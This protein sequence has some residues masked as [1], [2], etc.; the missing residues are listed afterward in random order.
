MEFICVS[1]LP[2]QTSR[3]VAETH[4]NILNMLRFIFLVLLADFDVAVMMELEG[5]TKEKQKVF[6]NGIIK[7]KSWIYIHI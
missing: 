5:A 1:P 4:F 6:W 3:V 7:W 2:P